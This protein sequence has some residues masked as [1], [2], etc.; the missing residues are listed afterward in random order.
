MCI[1]VKKNMTRAANEKIREIDMGECGPPIKISHNLSCMSKNIVYVAKDLV[2]GKVYVGQTGREIKRRHADHLGDISRRD[3]RKPVSRYFAD[4]NLSEQDF[5][6][7]PVAQI[8]GSKVE[9]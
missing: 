4:K 8:R 2:H 3:I 5:W 1:H 9:R 6:M 7:A